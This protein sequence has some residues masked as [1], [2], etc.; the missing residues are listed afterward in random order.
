MLSHTTFPA[1]TIHLL[2]RR[3]SHTTSVLTNIAVRGLLDHLIVSGTLLNQS[4]HFF[5]SEERANVCLLPFLLKED[6]KYGD[7]E[8]FRTYKGMKYQGGISDHLP[9]YADFE[10][11]YSTD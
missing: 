1:K 3:R 5:T 7:K 11:K 9:V 6:E 4:S 8:P 10:L 2:A